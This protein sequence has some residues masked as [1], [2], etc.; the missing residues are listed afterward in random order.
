MDIA[1]SLSHLPISE[2]SLAQMQNSGPNWNQR[3]GPNMPSL[4]LASVN[5]SVGLS[6][7]TAENVD[8]FARLFASETHGRSPNIN[9]SQSDYCGV[10]PLSQAFTAGQAQN[11]AQEELSGP[12][13]NQHQLTAD[14]STA[15]T[16][17][18][19]RSVFSHGSASSLS[20]FC[21]MAALNI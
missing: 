4:P 6:D 17:M 7:P 1:A 3:A 8:N 16:A 13:L 11:G 21:F 14:S 19:S 5:L 10:N 18:V 12:L 15:S 2:S 20:R 9:S